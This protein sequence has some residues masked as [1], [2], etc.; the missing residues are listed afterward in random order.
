[1]NVGGLTVRLAKYY[2]VQLIVFIE[3]AHLK[4]KVIHRRLCPQNILIFINQQLKVTNFRHA[5]NIGDLALNVFEHGSYE[6]CQLPRVEEGLNYMSP[7]F[8]E[9]RSDAESRAMDLWSLGC[10]IYEMVTGR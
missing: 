8:I 5:K 10:I 9:R 3:E 2:A 6:D 1:M 7:E 4:Q